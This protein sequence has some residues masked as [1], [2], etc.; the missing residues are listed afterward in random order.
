MSAAKHK[1]SVTKTT[2]TRKLRP[3]AVEID[4]PDGSDVY[5]VPHISKLSYSIE[6]DKNSYNLKDLIPLDEFEDMD[7][8]KPAPKKNK[9]RGRPRKS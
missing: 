8:E 9:K 5:E 6:Q 7:K 4:D 1:S 2:S 3:R